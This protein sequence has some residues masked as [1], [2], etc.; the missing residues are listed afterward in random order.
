MIGLRRPRSRTTLLPGLDSSG[1]RRRCFSAT[2]GGMNGLIRASL[3]N[4]YAV[5]VMALTLAVLGVLSIRAIPVDILPVFKSPAVQMLTFYGGM[6]AA[7]IEKDITNR[8]ERWVGQANGHDAAG[9]ALD[10]RRQHRPQLLPERRRPQRRPDRRSTRWPWPRSP[11]CRRARCRR[12]SC[13]STRR[14]RRPSASSPSTAPTRRTDESV[15]YDVGP[16][17]GPQHDHGASGRGRPGGLR[18]QGPRRHGS[19]STARSCRPAASRRST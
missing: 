4:P 9:V 19:T 11:T 10:R 17:R 18:R 6:P 16:V 15:L 3:K 2:G 1:H 8:M 14:A 12:S 5:T 7:S 13:R